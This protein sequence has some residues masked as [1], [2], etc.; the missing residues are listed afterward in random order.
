MDKPSVGETYL[1]VEQDE[2]TKERLEQIDIQLKT[3]DTYQKLTRL[4]KKVNETASSELWKQLDDLFIEYHKEFHTFVH[5]IENVTDNEIIICE[6]VRLG[7]NP[8]LI[9]VIMN[10][11]NSYI[12]TIRADL[13]YKI[14]GKKGKPKEVDKYLIS[15]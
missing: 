11:S 5:S 12:A 9:A 7:F 14:F 10:C 13:H 6:L 4:T 8:S 15:I 2:S 1:I 3:S